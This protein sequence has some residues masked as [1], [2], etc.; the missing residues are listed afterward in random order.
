MSDSTDCNIIIVIS[1]GLIFYLFY[2]KGNIRI[3]ND[4][5]NI[6]CNPITLFLS[7]INSDP[8]ESIGTFSSCVNDFTSKT[9]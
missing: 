5:L 7:S 6:K 9:L 8:I 3:K 2:L 4:W 1:L